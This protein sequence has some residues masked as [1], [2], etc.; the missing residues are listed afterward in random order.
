MMNRIAAVCR[1]WRDLSIDYAPFWTS[2]S[3][4][5][6]IRGGLSTSRHTTFSDRMRT[7]LVRSKHL[8]IAVRIR[9]CSIAAAQGVWN[10]VYPHLE[11]C[12]SLSIE[13]RGVV[14]CMLFPLPGRLTHLKNVAIALD[15]VCINACLFSTDAKC[16]LEKVEITFHSTFP[17]TRPHVL[18]IEALLGRNIRLDSIKYFDLGDTFSP[19]TSLSFL[20]S[21]K[22]LEVLKLHTSGPLDDSLSADLRHLKELYLR[23]SIHLSAIP[24]I[25]LAPSLHHLQLYVSQLPP[26]DI[27]LPQDLS[28]FP[29]LRSLDLDL[30]F[31]FPVPETIQ[32]LLLHPHLEKVIL[33]LHQTGAVEFLLE[34]NGSPEFGGNVGPLRH[35][36][37]LMDMDVFPQV[38]SLSESLES[39]LG[40]LL[41]HP[42]TAQGCVIKFT[43]NCQHMLPRKPGSVSRLQAAYPH[44]VQWLNEDNWGILSRRVEAPRKKPTRRRRLT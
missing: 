11:R 27:L 42:T 37:L 28:T 12:K 17:R 30:P 26:Q 41:S 6:R 18:P 19:T 10:L 23:T 20:Q 13:D 5:D 8:L 29:A 7:Y 44:R 1:L 3:Y 40:R 34:T 22:N 16:E 32:F 35:L 14:S 33:P 25:F 43:S 21:T 36:G 31:S 38:E 9:I 39:S 24:H 4:S 15:G 2:I